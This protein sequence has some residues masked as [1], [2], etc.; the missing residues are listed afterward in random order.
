MALTMTQKKA[1]TRE[2]AKKYRAARK[3]EKGK[4][5]NDL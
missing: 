5:L 3:K 2:L 4:I 1:A